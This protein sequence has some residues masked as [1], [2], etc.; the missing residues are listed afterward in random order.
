MPA[1]DN[2]SELITDRK[3]AEEIFLSGCKSQENIGVESEKLLVYKNDMTAV[4]YDDV[5]KILNRFDSDKYEKVFENGNLTG[6][7]SKSASVSLEPG[8]QTE[9]S[10]SPMSDLTEISD[11]LSEFYTELALY[12]KEYDAIVLNSGIQPVSV[13]NDIEVIPKKRYEY[14]TNYLPS[15][16]TAPFVMMRETAGVQVNFDYKSEEDAVKK[17]SLAIK[18]SSIVAS[19]Y[20]NSPVRGSELTGYKSFR[21]N[22]WLNVDEQRCG[23]IHKKL[24]EKNTSFTFK[25]YVD[26]LFDIPMIFIQREGKYYKTSMTFAEFMKNGFE[27]LKATSADWENHISLYFPDVRLKSYL[28]IRNH[29][30][31]NDLMTFSVPAFWKGIIYNPSAME[32]INDILSGYV[33][34][35]YISLRKNMPVYGVDAKLGNTPVIEPVKRFFDI[36][37]ESLKSSGK[38]EQKFLEPVYEYISQGRVPADDII[39]KFFMKT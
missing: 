1:T 27:G 23:L 7:K 25:D 5:V 6:L 36:S 35:D 37:F 12:A 8:S 28:E 4:K 9:I 20:C 18:M 22:S 2:L 31:Q 32:E 34:E 14:M 3:Q 29:D 11:K 39:E 21:A 33:Y 15:K 24:F 38:N 16:G 10:L 17:L 30:A 19:I 13:F 26:V